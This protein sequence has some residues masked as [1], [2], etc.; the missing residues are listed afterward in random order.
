MKNVS[1]FLKNKA[2]QNAVIFMSGSGTNAEKIL[3]YRKIAGK[4]NWNP[5]AIVTDA[6]LKSRAREI[7]ERF[8]LPL[9]EHDIRSFYF[10]RGEK[11][12]SIKSPKGQI[13][14]EEWTNKL[15][16]K[17][18]KYNIDFGILAGFIPLTNITSD[19]PCLNVHPG[20][21]T[22]ENDGMRTLV[23]LHNVP[24]EK[25]IISGHEYLRSSVIIAQIY[26]GAGGEMDSGPILGLSPE[27]KIDYLSYNLKELIDCFKSRS[28][29]KSKNC[30]GDKLEEVADFNLEKLKKSGDWIVFPRVVDDFAKNKFA[31]DENVNQLYFLEKNN[32]VPVKTVVYTENIKKII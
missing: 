9:I 15:R 18:L 12:I 2:V 29:L 5:V 3:E 32:F 8:E 30:Y 6:P 20:D 1:F 23:G 26:T 27:V 21:L 25:A 22:V 11:R 7:A 13:I 28:K 10:S 19:F 4:S 16:S 31:F 24:I 17:I 14:R